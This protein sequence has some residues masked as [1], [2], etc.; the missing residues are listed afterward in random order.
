MSTRRPRL[1]VYQALCALPPRVYDR[2]AE[3]I[4]AE[5]K[6]AQQRRASVVLR[7]A[8][9]RKPGQATSALAS[10][11][12]SAMGLLALLLELAG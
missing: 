8:R 12:A 11:A 9:G 3:T 6:H 4:L 2:F 7:A 10:R 5:A 1:A